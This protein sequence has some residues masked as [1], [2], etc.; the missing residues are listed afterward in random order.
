MPEKTCLHCG[1]TFTPGTVYD[2]TGR[3]SSST[4]YFDTAKYCSERC[5]QNAARKRRR[6]RQRVEGR[7]NASETAN[8]LNAPEGTANLYRAPSTNLADYAPELRNRLA[9]GKPKEASLAVTAGGKPITSQKDQDALIQSL[10]S[11]PGSSDDV[12]TN[13]YGKKEEK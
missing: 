5:R 12:I 11:L 2:L 6:E 10:L 1:Y 13:L 3:P 9:S 7:P 4:Y 8:P